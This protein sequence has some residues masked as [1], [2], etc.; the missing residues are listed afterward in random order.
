[1]EFL[2]ITGL[3]GAGK[4][5]AADVLEDLDYYC[6][7]NM[8]VALMPRF[9][10]LCLATRGRYER[11]ALVT[12]VRERDGFGELLSTLEE[13]GAMDCQI[14]IL[15]MDADVRTLVRRYKESRRP[16]PLAAAG[17]SVEQAVRREEE[18]LAP[19]KE[20]ADFIVNSSNLTLGMLQNRLFSLFAAEG[21]KREIDVTVMSFGYK[22]GLPMDADLV[23]DARFLPNPYYV[24]ELRP[25]C[26]LDRPV[27]E[28]VFSYQ[29]TRIFMEKMEDLV[30]FLLPLYIEEGKLGLTIAIGC[31][32]GRHRSV[33]I[34]AALN[35]YLQA[36]GLS[37][38]NVN[39]DLDK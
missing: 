33:A 32:G 29:Q 5:R 9:A 13:L 16:H 17:V 35:D 14:R 24:E 25:M 4:S 10:E 1:M 36:K 8:P 19:I 22:H 38:V 39:R 2:I 31:T 7:D 6:V 12:D 34:A 15:Y 3:S 26:G 23:F 11:V 30:S 20:R 37:S 28:F 27:A 21:K 18:L